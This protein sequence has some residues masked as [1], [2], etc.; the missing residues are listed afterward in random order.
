MDLQKLVMD[1][2]KQQDR[3][4][5]RLDEQTTALAKEREDRKAEVAK[6][7]TALAKQTTALAKERE[8]R[9]AEVAKERKDRADERDRLEDKLEKQDRL[10]EETNKGHA[11]LKAELAQAKEELNSQIVAIT[12]VRTHRPLTK[13]LTFFCLAHR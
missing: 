5:A 2:R 9:K 11:N 12:Q 13:I 8:D 1:L 4:E 6:Q 3:L 10:L 7:T